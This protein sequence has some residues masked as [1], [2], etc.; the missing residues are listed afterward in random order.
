MYASITF[1]VAWPL[2]DF[3]N[4]NLNVIVVLVIVSLPFV[5]PPLHQSQLRYTVLRLEKQ[6][7]PN[8]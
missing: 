1:T 5:Y 6:H 7:W 4:A 3:F 2:D 8:L